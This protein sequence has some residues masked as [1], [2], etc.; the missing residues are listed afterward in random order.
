MFES[1]A[2]PLTTPAVLQHVSF[3]HNHTHTHSYTS[4]K[5]GSSVSKN[6][7]TTSLP[8]EKRRSLT[9]SLLH[10]YFIN[11][12]TSNMVPLIKMAAIKIPDWRQHSGVPG[13]NG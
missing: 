6:W 4:G 10:R 11:I 2:C 3:S 13:A 5:A 12:V 8:A 9:Y 1:I 7:W